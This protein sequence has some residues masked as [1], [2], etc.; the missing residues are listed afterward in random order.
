M[1]R[2]SAPSP[3]TIRFGAAAFAVASL[4]VP[5]FGVTLVNDLM[6]DTDRIGG[7]DG[8]ASSGQTINAP[9][10]SNTQWLSDSVNQLVASPSGLLWTRSA[11]PGNGTRM[12]TGYF[13]AVELQDGTITTFT[14]N[15]TLGNFGTSGNNLRMG[16]FDSSSS[17]FGRLEGDGPA[18]D[19]GGDLSYS[20]VPGYAFLTTTALGGTSTETPQFT[21]RER[22]ETSSLL[23]A[24]SSSSHY[25][26]LGA[27]HS[28]TSGHF[29]ANTDYT[30]TTTFTRS[31]STLDIGMA[32]TGGN[33][34]GLEFTRQDTSISATFLDQ[35]SF[36]TSGR[37]EQFETVNFTGFSV[38]QIPEPSFLAALA[39]LAAFGLAATRRRRPVA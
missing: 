28:A 30:L 33:L 1:K 35:F 15:F 38:T 3:T 2:I 19:G 32:I 26:Q 31:G 4:T 18:A 25:T 27:A 16:F 12:V 39:S 6:N 13:P 23:L 10:S 24:S 14:L 37:D 22:T 7:F 36:R 34:V 5:A 8:S 11:T 29:E 20:G 17:T 9:T 21:I